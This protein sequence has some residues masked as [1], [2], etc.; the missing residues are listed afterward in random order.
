MVPGLFLGVGGLGFDGA[1]ACS[2]AAGAL[3]A[4]RSLALKSKAGR[5]SWRHGV[6]LGAGA[7]A[8]AVAGV[9]LLDREEGLLQ[10]GRIV[11]GLLLAV[12]ALRFAREAL[13]GRFS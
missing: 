2:L 8:G 11:L 6:P 10:V 4:A 1:R 3:G 13:R 5:V 7:L 9:V 12:V